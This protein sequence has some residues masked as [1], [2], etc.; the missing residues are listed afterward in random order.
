M[1]A[2]ATCANICRVIKLDGGDSASCRLYT[3]RWGDKVPS[4]SFVR[5]TDSAQYRNFEL[6]SS[7]ST[8]R[9]HAG[10]R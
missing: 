5:M 1:S 6:S 7:T 2:L 8:P 10:D 4:S 3:P 9:H